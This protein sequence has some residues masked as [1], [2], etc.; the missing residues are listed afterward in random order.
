VLYLSR[1][2]GLFVSNSGS[3]CTDVVAKFR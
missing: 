3:Y 2:P 1:T